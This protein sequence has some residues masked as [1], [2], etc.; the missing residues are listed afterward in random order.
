VESAA[1]Q[2]S[3]FHF[4]VT[5][6]CGQEVSPEGTLDVRGL[7]GVRVL[8]VDDNATNR[9]I[10]AESLSLWGMQ[11]LIAENARDA[12][13]LYNSSAVSIP[14]ILTDVH[15]P[16]MDGFELA[17]NIKN[18]AS[19]ATIVL[20]TSGSHAGDVARCKDLSIEGYLTKPV[21]QK[22]LQAAILRVLQPHLLR[23]QSSA[24]SETGN[25]PDTNGIRPPL[26]ILL[27]E[28]N[29]VNQKVAVRMLQNEGHTVTVANN[30]REVL[31]ALER[32]PFQLILMDVQM[33]EMDGFEATAAIRA[34]ERFTGA[35][36]PIIAMTA[37]AMAGDQ[38]RCLGAGM[39]GYISK[40]VHKAELV[41]AINA[42]RGLAE[43]ISSGLA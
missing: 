6:S 28:D 15:M 24:P 17:A 16:D 11:P 40:P 7:A 29:V 25:A 9:S 8:V 19:A 43:A 20:L 38:E 27:A 1:G 42:L 26:R 10:L 22:D 35:H 2:G 4:T 12:I 37:H 34:R 14:L 21:S 30:G 13:D 23:A 5:A 18:R 41:Q 39:D 33:P 36:L 31:A 32:E 3:A